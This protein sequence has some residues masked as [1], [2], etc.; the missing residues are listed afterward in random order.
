VSGGWCRRGLGVR[1]SR[2]TQWASVTKVKALGGKYAR[3]GPPGIRYKQT[4]EMTLP[5]SRH[6][7]MV[8]VRFQGRS[9]QARDQCTFEPQRTTVG[10]CS[11][12]RF[13]LADLPQDAERVL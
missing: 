11:R 7:S 2:K 13:N 10:F 3:S 1:H 8:E 12:T 6:S 5:S 9:A 4:A